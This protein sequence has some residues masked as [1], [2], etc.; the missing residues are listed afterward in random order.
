MECTAT[1]ASGKTTGKTVQWPEVE[2]ERMDGKIDPQSIGQ[3]KLL[4]TALLKDWPLV[5]SQYTKDGT[6]AA[7]LGQID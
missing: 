4:D 2:C 1:E 3:A 6:G 5:T 7:L